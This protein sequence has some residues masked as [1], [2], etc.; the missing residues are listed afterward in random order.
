MVHGFDGAAA[1]GDPVSCQSV[2]VERPWLS[3]HPAGNIGGGP[4]SDLLPAANMREVDTVTNAPRRAARGVAVAVVAVVVAM[5][6]GTGSAVAAKTKTKTTTVNV[7]VGDTTGLNGPMTMTVLPTSAPAGK[8]K[9][10]V[11]NNGTILHEF[12]VLKLKGKTTYEQ[13]VV[14][15]KTNE[16]SEATNVGEVGNVPKGKTKS[17]TLTLKKGNY[18]LVCNIAKHYALGMRAPFTVN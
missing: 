12:I 5:G 6:L 14:N 10:V 11:T 1:G 18:A 15:P 3:S 8:V 9:F 17:K 13:L 4:G 16:V 2:W 7:V